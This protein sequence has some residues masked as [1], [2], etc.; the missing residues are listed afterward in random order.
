MC[1]LSNRFTFRKSER[2]CGKNEIET[3]YRKGQSKTIFPFK[4]FWI[5]TEQENLSP[6][7]ILISVP[8]RNFKKAHDRN[9]I[10]RQIREAYRLL[11]LPLLKLTEKEMV[12]ID[13]AFLYLGKEPV[14]QLSKKMQKSLDFL[15]GEISSR[16]T[17]NQQ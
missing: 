6:C 4:L 5:F 9:R 8:K 3:L 10:K 14:S 11:K 17:E 7:R 2:I 1:A 16:L 12:G 15:C 13:I